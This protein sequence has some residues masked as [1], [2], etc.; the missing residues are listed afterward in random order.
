MAKVQSNILNNMVSNSI[1]YP[2][3]FQ[4]QGLIYSLRLYWSTYLVHLLVK[5]ENDREPEY[6]RSNLTVYFFLHLTVALEATFY[7]KPPVHVKSGNNNIFFAI[8]AFSH[9]YSVAETCLQYHLQH[10]KAKKFLSKS[11][12]L[13]Y[14]LNL[15][16]LSTYSTHANSSKVYRH[17]SNSLSEF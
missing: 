9:K 13:F 4:N 1:F 11:C 5:V 8:T 15:L 10:Y 3:F 17:V 12:K 2:R 16:Y 14:L 7:S 6:I